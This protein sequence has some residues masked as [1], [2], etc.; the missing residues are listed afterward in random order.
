[1]PRLAQCALA[2]FMALALLS[3]AGQAKRLMPIAPSIPIRVA[4]AETIVLGKVERIEDQSVEVTESPDEKEKKEYFVAMVHIEEAVKGA[5]GL[6]DLK[7]AFP[8]LPAN[9]KYLPNG[10]DEYRLQLETDQEVCLFLKP[11]H[12]GKFLIAACYYPSFDKKDTNFEENWKWTQQCA[13][14]LANPEEGLQAKDPDERFLTAAMLILQYRTRQ[15]MPKADAKEEPIPAK[16]SRLILQALGEG[17]WEKPREDLGYEMR[18]ESLFSRLNLTPKDGWNQ[19]VTSDAARK[20]LKENAE[21]Y[22][23]KRFLAESN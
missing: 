5:E 6:T 22:R 21:R 9:L 13:K 11:H 16:Q 10:A 4:A 14:L 15:F 23:I 12:S 2:A 1:M 18:P 8:A 20:W 7:V 17:N 3:A 19:A